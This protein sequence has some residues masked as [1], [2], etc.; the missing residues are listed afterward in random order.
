[1]RAIIILALVPLTGC[2][3][4]PPTVPVGY[5]PPVTAIP[6]YAPAYPPLDGVPHARAREWMADVP[7]WTPGDPVFSRSE[8]NR[9]IDR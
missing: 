4:A 9:G 2:V 5:V 1:M 6:G 8:P 3:V 7:H